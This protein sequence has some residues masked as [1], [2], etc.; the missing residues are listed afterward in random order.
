M[1]PSL[2]EGL[3]CKHEDLRLQPQ[4]PQKRARQ[5]ETSGFVPGDHWAASLDNP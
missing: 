2:H 3:L 1:A 5:E 4:H